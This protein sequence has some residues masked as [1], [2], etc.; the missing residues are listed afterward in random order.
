VLK[1]LANGHRLVAISRLDEAWSDSREQGRYS[2]ML[3]E[4]VCI[5]LFVSHAER[6]LVHG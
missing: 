3:A 1:T 2:E 5:G 4:C 6:A